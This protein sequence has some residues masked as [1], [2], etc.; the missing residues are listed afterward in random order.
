M[1]MDLI[2]NHKAI[3]IESRLVAFDFNMLHQVAVEEGIVVCRFLNIGRYAGIEFI[4]Y[5]REYI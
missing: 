3:S 2:P 4:P 1:K 5:I